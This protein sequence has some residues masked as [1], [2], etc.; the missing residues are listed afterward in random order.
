MYN[1]ASWTLRV[2]DIVEGWSMWKRI[3]PLAISLLWLATVGHAQVN[4][5]T[6]NVEVQDSSGAIM[7]GAAI[8]LTHVGSGQVRQGTASATGTF[9]APFMPVGEYTIRVE[10]PGFKSKTITGV[11]LAVDQNPT[12]TVA[13]DPGEVREVVEVNA[14][15]PLLEANTSSIGQVVDNKKIVELPLNGRNP[16]ALGTLA[17]NTTPIFGLGTNLPFVGGGGR[18]ESN[19]IMIDGAEDNTTQNGN[20]IG[21]AGA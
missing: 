17:G 15:T 1:P 8:T 7:P 4:S 2:E 6:I 5:G 19:E 10:V 21:R 14:A 16:F 3:A 12:I 13:L 18:A 9:R 20:N 11:T